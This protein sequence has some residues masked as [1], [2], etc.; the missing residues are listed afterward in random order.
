MEN[1]TGLN[2]FSYLM[3]YFHLNISSIVISCFSSSCASLCTSSFCI[4]SILNISSKYSF[5]TFSLYP[6]SLYPQ[7][8]DFFLASSLCSRISSPLLWSS[9]SSA[10]FHRLQ[11]FLLCHLSLLFLE[12]IS[13]FFLFWFSLFKFSLWLLY[14]ILKLFIRFTFNKYVFC[15]IVFF[16]NV[17]AVFHTPIQFLYYTDFQL[18]LLYINPLII[19]YL[20]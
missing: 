14:S 20:L 3:L 5:Q 16:K 11:H 19:S 1:C 9:S 4:A 13:E 2:V 17:P 18:H 15:C 10:F 8:S 7:S 12:I 6:Q